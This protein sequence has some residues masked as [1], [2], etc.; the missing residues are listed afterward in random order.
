MYVV[1]IFFIAEL[2]ESDF[3]LL[4]A[5]FPFVDFCLSFNLLPKRKAQASR[6][7]LLTLSVSTSFSL[8][9]S[10]SLWH[11]LTFSKFSCNLHIFLAFIY[12][13]NK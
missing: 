10:L 11:R 4:A 5:S 3:V 8:S 12:F 7:R 9:L 1:F 6:S 13:A 2:I